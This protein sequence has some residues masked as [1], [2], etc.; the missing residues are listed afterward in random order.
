MR[1]FSAEARANA[2]SLT[3]SIESF[4]NIARIW[5]EGRRITKSHTSILGRDIAQDDAP[6]LNCFSVD[7]INARSRASDELKIWHVFQEALLDGCCG[8]NDDGGVF[9]L[10]WVGQSASISDDFQ[11]VFEGERRRLNPGV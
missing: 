7:V 2:C 11:G 10:L 9:E 6:S 8:I 1:R 4:I 5:L 3:V